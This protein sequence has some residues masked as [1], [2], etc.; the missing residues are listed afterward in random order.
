MAYAWQRYGRLRIK[1]YYGEIVHMR[2]E[3]LHVI[4]ATVVIKPAADVGV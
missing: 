3:I 2:F 1:Q 4:A